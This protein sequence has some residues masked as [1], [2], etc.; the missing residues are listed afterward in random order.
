MDIWTACKDAA[1]PEVLS[2]ELIRVVERQE[3][4]A[5]THLVDSLAE[6]ILLEEMLEAVKPPIPP[7]AAKLHYLL[8]TPFRY[9]PLRHGS[10]FGPRDEPGLFYGSLDLS[11]ALAEAAYYRFVFW[12]GMA[13]PPAAERLMSEHT[14]FGA[15]YQFA[16]GFRLQTPPFDAYVELLTAAGD[17]TATQQLGRAMRAAGVVGFEYRSARDA[18][19]G[20][21]IGLFYARAFSDTRPSWQEAWRCETRGDRVTLY[22]RGAGQWIF[23]REQFLVDGIL[24]SPAV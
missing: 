23:S 18:Q 22:N 21:N 17:Y 13:T 16:N 10:R 15:R 7:D 11:A 3:R 1:V 19:G 6:Q 20:I 2:G 5:T 4:V 8:A 9:P 14:V 24:P 12:S